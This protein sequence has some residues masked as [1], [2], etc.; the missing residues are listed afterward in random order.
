[1]W[2]NREFSMRM[3]EDTFRD[4][5]R[6]MLTSGDCSLFM[7][8][9]FMGEDGGETV[10]YDCSGFA[11]I[12]SYSIEKTDDALYILECVLLIVGRS[13]EYFITPARITVTEDTVFYNKE[14]RNVKIAYIPVQTA[15]AGVRS[16]LVRFIEQLKINICDGNQR[17]LD[18][19][20]RYIMCHN[21][22]IRD[23]VNKIGAFKREIYRNS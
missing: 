19:A 7:P 3:E 4:Y 15:D 1:M 20:A 6:I 5:E 8:M 10:C 23:M 18:D 2:G 9:G 21:Y 12:S 22:H 17:Y 16:N 14:T 13:V 11:P